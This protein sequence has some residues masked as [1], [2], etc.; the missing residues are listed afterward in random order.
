MESKKTLV[1]GATPDAS[2]YAYIATKMLGDYD[3]KVVPFGIKKG[4]INGHIILNEPPQDLDFDTVTLYLGP[5]NQPQYYDYIIGLDPK[6]VI[7]N[8]GTEN[9]EFEQM[10]TD[11]G[12]EPVE[13]C[14]LV[15]LRTGQY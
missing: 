4:A 6:R 10:L 1:I 7:F 12:I 13:A 8:P 15:M 3:H 14:T 11:K 9:P 2:R 5:Q